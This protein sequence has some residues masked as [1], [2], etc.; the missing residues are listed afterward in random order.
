MAVIV[1]V[2]V[3][4]AMRYLP[5]SMAWE[6]LPDRSSPTRVAPFSWAARL[7]LASSEAGPTVVSRLK[8]L[9]NR[10]LGSL[11]LP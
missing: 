11:L 3:R 4:S 10:I 6:K 5:A 9:V 8:V 1:T 2:T 7:A